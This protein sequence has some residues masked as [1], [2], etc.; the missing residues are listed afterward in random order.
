[1]ASWRRRP[2]SW[3][4][5]QA[6]VSERSAA[7]SVTSARRR[8]SAASSISRVTSALATSSVF[9]ASTREAQLR[10]GA[11]PL[12]ERGDHLG[13]P[14]PHR[15][16]GIGGHLANRAVEGADEPVSVD[17][18]EGV[19][20]PEQQARVGAHLLAVAR[21]HL[22]HQVAHRGAEIGTVQ[23]VGQRPRQRLD[24]A[25]IPP[26]PLRDLD[27][28]REHRGHRLLESQLAR[29][30]DD[31]GGGGGRQL[32]GDPAGDAAH[33]RLE[34]LGLHAVGGAGEQSAMSKRATS[35]VT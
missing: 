4:A 13:E 2:S 26:L 21:E 23:R 33:A 19:G 6:T 27:G 8:P 31:V 29:P 28:P 16:V 22:V 11:Q 24:G 1:M 18:A 32:I 35:C 14:A 10:V 7:R 5:I 25:L 3:A 17:Q 20:Q 9:A 15:I 34:L 30:A 12:R